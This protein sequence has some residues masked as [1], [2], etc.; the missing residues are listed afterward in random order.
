MAPLSSRFRVYN[1]VESYLIL[2][3]AI[4]NSVPDIANPVTQIRGHRSLTLQDSVV[5]E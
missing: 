1:W 3:L 5:S 4:P 2:S